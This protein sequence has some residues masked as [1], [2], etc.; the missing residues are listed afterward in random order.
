[1]RAYSF[2]NP[3]VPRAPSRPAN[4]L[5]FTRI[6]IHNMYLFIKNS[7]VSRAG[8]NIRFLVFTRAYEGE[9]EREREDTVEG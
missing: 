4:R 3:P 7:K 8:Q 6:Q 2:Y 1:M 9:R 5:L